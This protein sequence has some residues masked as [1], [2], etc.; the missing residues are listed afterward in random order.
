MRRRGWTEIAE[1]MGRYRREVVESWPPF[2]GYRTD[3]A[4]VH[5]RKLIRGAKLAAIDEAA[6]RVCRALKR[7]SSRFD[8][9]IFMRIVSGALCVA[10]A[11]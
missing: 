5:D 9:K 4:D 2:G 6:R 10:G 7:S 8:G 1:A 11:L 3:A